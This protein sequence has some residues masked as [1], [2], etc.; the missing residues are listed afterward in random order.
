MGSA[1]SSS[2]PWGIFGV[3]TDAGAE[4]EHQ[5]QQQQ[6]PHDARSARVSTAA[7]SGQV[8]ACTVNARTKKKF[9]HAKRVA[10]TPNYLAR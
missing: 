7:P 10:P 8:A 2:S 9:A 4:A 3:A 1:R 5:W 6:Q